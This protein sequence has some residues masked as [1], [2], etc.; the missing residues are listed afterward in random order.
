MVSKKLKSDTTVTWALNQKDACK[1]VIYNLRL[2]SSKLTYMN[3][4]LFEFKLI[5]VRELVQFEKWY[6]ELSRPITARGKSNEVNR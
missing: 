5:F 1:L 6:Q 3:S 2:M 4:S